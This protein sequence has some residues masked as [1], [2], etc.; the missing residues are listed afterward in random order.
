MIEDHGIL[1]CLLML[2]YGGNGQ[3]FGGYAFDQWDENKKC[4][5]GFAYGIDFILGIFKALDIYEWGNLTGKPIRVD[6]DGEF[7]K[8]LGIGHFIKDSWFYPEELRI[9]MQ[10]VLR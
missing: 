2:D 7:G 1:T 3:G 8:I 10:T 9:K 5:V 6:T 4:R